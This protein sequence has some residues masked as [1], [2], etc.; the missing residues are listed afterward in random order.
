MNPL[1]IFPS[2][3]R[4][5]RGLSALFWGLPLMLLCDARS[6][7][8]D[9]LTEYGWMPVVAASV[10]V[11]YGLHQ[12]RHFQSQERIWTASLDRARL[13]SLLLVALSP[14]TYWWNRRPNEPFFAQSMVLLVF[15]GF[16]FL[17]ALNHVLLRLSAMLPDETLRAETGFFTGINQ[18]LIVLQAGLTAGEML[19]VRWADAP[20]AIARL[21]DA[22]EASK[23][24]L[25]L[26]LTLLPVALTMTLLWKTKEVIIASVFRPPP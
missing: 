10:L 2:L 23:S 25:V 5:V 18:T 26:L 1:G 22:F 24:W 8:D 17:I 3:A 4:V 20:P 12:L 13:L 14:F 7:M 15:A 9:S 19:L 16:A 6:A 21:R 11:A